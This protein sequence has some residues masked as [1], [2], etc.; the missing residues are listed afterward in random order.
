MHKAAPF[1]HH[2]APCQNSYSICE[3]THKVNHAELTGSQWP[4][5]YPQYEKGKDTGKVLQITEPRVKAVP[6]L[7]ATTVDFT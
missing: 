1:P 4:A 5:V 7:S 3:V 2:N 6:T